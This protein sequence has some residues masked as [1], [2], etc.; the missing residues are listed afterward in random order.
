MN[1]SRARELIGRQVVVTG[2]QKGRGIVGIVKSVRL[3]PAT[4]W[5]CIIVSEGDHVSYSVYL[6]HVHP[7]EEA[8]RAQLP[9]R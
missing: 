1:A 9:V 4:V 7:I 5:S 2:G 8:H 6:K 3:D